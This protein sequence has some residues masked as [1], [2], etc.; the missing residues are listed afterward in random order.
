MLRNFQSSTPPLPPNQPMPAVPPMS[1]S[2][3]MA[4]PY[5]SLYLPAG[6]PP[7]PTTVLKRP[8][9]LTAAPL[10]S[11]TTSAMPKR[12]P[13]SAR[14]ILTAI[15]LLALIPLIGIGVTYGILYFNGQ[16]RANTPQALPPLAKATVQPTSGAA[17]STPTTSATGSTLP[18]PTSFSTMSS[19]HQKTLGV[20]IKY[21]RDWVED[22]ATSPTS[23]GTVV[24][25]FHPQQQLGII[26][27]V[28][29]FPIASGVAS[30]A[31]LNQGL[32]QTIYQNGGNSGN[33]N[34]QSVQ[35][36]IPHPTIGGV[37]WDEQ[38]ATYSDPNGLLIHINSIAIKHGVSIYG[39]LILT[40]DLYYNDVTQKYV[41]PMLSSFKFIA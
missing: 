36:A 2:P 37:P 18:T 12:K 15:A 20:L 14:S 22:P 25:R 35:P 23:D 38:D 3:Q 13:R 4:S 34:L 41:P 21:P 8:P 31:A 7:W 26:F 33:T 1:A 32:I 19:D 17:S 40:P 6:A 30:S 27:F 10:T 28:G 11:T 24:A 5:A 16:V 39:F 29:K 9:L